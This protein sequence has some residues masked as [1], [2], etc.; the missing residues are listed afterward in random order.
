MVSVTQKTVVEG[1]GPG[2]RFSALYLW[3]VEYIYGFHWI[4]RVL[5]SMSYWIF[6]K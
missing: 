4:L 3:E 2:S 6:V 1:T 5:G